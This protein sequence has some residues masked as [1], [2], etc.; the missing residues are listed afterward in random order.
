MPPN[1]SPNGVPANGLACCF[2][3]IVCLVEMFTTA[4]WSRATMSA[5]LIGAPGLG[6]TAW[7]APGSF[8]ATWPV[9]EAV[10]GWS[11][12]VAVAPPSSRALVMA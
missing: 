8:W 6:T 3:T 7:I 5:K 4:G 11:A 10:P 2:W 9:P 1:S 12:S